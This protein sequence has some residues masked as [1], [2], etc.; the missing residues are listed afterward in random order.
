MLDAL[1]EYYDKKYNERMRKNVKE[2]IGH[3]PK[4]YLLALY[5]EITYAYTARYGKLPDVA[6]VAKAMGGMD[7]PASFRD[8]PKEIEGPVEIITQAAIKAQELKVKSG[9]GNREEVDRVGVRIAK[10][11]ASDWEKHWYHCMTENGGKWI[12]PAE[13][14]FAEELA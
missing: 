12:N 10:G 6:V 14:P 1:E 8:V 11:N 9:I 13:G 2:A 3:P 4:K 5:K 7:S